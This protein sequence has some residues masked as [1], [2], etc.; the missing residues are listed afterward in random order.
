MLYNT[1]NDHASSEEGNT[2][3]FICVGSRRDV[4]SC[5]REPCETDKAECLLDENGTKWRP[6]ILQYR[7]NGGFN[8]SLKD[9]LENSQV[10]I[11]QH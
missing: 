4:E 1:N 8:K 10:K 6:L 9:C 2:G 5:N 7:E 3:N 11:G